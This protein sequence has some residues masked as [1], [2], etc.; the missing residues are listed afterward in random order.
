MDYFGNLVMATIDEGLDIYSAVKFFWYKKWL[1]G[2]LSL[3]FTFQPG[4]L[5]AIS[6]SNL[7]DFFQ[8]LP[9]VNLYYTYKL[10][11][12]VTGCRKE[13]SK[14]EAGFGNIVTPEDEAH[15]EKANENLRKAES[16][17]MTIKVFT[18]MGEAAPQF[19]LQTAILLKEYGLGRWPNYGGIWCTMEF[20]RLVGK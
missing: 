2:S 20:V 7:K 11:V 19:I 15:L 1:Y 18:A 4:I 3:Y 5:A 13:V 17:L 6:H 12:K 8:L 14:C 16:E 9:V 10:L